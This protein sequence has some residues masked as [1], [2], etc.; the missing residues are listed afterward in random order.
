MS[1]KECFEH[2]IQTLERNVFPIGGG[3]GWE[4]VKIKH[5]RFRTKVGCLMYKILTFASLTM[6]KEDH[7]RSQEE[8]V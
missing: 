3:V 6:Q 1:Y 8:K 7:G 2:T 5:D 4:G